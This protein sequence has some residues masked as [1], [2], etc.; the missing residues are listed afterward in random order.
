VLA[1]VPRVPTVTWGRDELAAD[2]MWNSNSVVRW[3][4]ARSG[5]DPAARPQRDRSRASAL[6]RAWPRSRRVGGRVAPVGAARRRRAMAPVDLLLTAALVFAVN[7]MPA[8][9][10]PTWSVLVVLKLSFGIPAVPLVAVGAIAAAA[11]RY[12][13]A[14]G[15]WRVA[16]GAWRVAR[17][18]WR[19]ARGAWRV[20]RGAWR[21]GGRLSPSVRRA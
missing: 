3:L 1:L 21:C 20:A 8:F 7:I 2:E 16:R 13:L 9:G 12:S 4:L 14:R 11:G 17:G 19:V 5:I 15:A 10:P 6:A 18:A